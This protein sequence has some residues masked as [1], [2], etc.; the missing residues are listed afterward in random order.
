VIFNPSWTVPDK[1]ARKEL[2]PKAERDNGYFARQGIQLIGTWQPNADGDGGTR[3]VTLRQAPGPKNPLGRVKF[4]LPNVFGVYLHD[5]ANRNLFT[6]EKRT[7]SH[8]CV[9]VGG[10]LDFADDVLAGHPHWSEERKERILSDWKTTT[11]GLEKPIPVHMMYQT[12]WID[13]RRAH[14]ID[15]VYGRDRRLAE[16]SRAAGQVAAPSAS[17][18]RRRS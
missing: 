12:A 11:I 1:I 2:L 15:D 7:L 16:P 14:F 13:P 8:G 5:T 17:P 9:R 3:G 10:A 6:R 4:L 18:S